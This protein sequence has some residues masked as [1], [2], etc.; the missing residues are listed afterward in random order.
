MVWAMIALSSPFFFCVFF[1]KSNIVK[2]HKF[3]LQLFRGSSATCQV[4]IF[5][6]VELRF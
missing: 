2:K 5:L 1:F 6:C 3:Y 4:L